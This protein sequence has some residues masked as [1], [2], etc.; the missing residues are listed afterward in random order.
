MLLKA[1]I[2]AKR[3]DEILE[4]KKKMEFR[5]FVG[6]D[7]MQVTDENGRIVDLKI[8]SMHEASEELSNDIKKKHK[9]EHMKWDVA[10]P[11]MIIKVEPM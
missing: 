11:V 4:G 6:N 1:K 2:K 9:D 3:L 5:Q 7:T 10:E 8:L